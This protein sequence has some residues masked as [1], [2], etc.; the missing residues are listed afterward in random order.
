MSEYKHK[1]DFTQTVDRQAKRKLKAR[2]EKSRNVWF[3]LGLFG[4]IG[5]SIMIPTLAGIALGLWLDRQWPG[6]VSWTLTMLLLGVVLG[7]VNAWRWI[8]EESRDD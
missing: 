6:Q 5:W 1:T 2:R 3:G 8:G 7:C 4:L